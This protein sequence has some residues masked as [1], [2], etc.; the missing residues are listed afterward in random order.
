MIQLRS[1]YDA[2]KQKATKRE[3]AAPYATAAR[4]SESVDAQFAALWSKSE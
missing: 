1:I 4:V 2:M 3:M